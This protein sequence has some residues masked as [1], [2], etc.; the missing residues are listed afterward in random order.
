[1]RDEFPK[2]VIN[3]MKQRA[4]FIC[5]NPSCRCLTIQPS[6]T[7]P[8]AVLVLGKVCHITA[9]AEGGPRF[10][11]TLTPEAR[12]SSD[13]ALYL[14]STCAD[15]IDKKGGINYP[16]DMLREWRVNH[17]KWVTQNLNKTMDH[18]ERPRLEP[19]FILYGDK[20]GTASFGVL[21][22]PV[23]EWPAVDVRIEARIQPP[24][25]GMP[26]VGR[27]RWDRLAAPLVGDSEK[28]I[29][30]LD[31][32][33]IPSEATIITKLEYSGT[34]GRSWTM[35]FHEDISKT[36]SRSKDVYLLW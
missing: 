10:N 7:D 1:M 28:L 17:E 25:D 21:L 9:A 29:P 26:S 35:D 14:C 27:C 11:P 36:I 34:D 13:N 31:M 24:M 15:L 19:E 12:Q 20:Q 32:T 5:S 4:A 6:P 22:H 3:Q 30:N 18:K 2:S 16:E 23:G 33:K 8:S